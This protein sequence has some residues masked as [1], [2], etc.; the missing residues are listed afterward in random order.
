M[1]AKATVCCHDN[2][3]HSSEARRRVD[4]DNGAPSL[5]TLSGE[6][7][8]GAGICLGYGEGDVPPTALGYLSLSY[9][10]CYSIHRTI[11]LSFGIME[12]NGSGNRLAWV[13]RRRFMPVVQP[14]KCRSRIRVGT[15][16][17]GGAGHKMKLM[18]AKDLNLYNNTNNHTELVS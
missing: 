5:S 13:Y 10:I 3:E 18:L 12:W 11:T 8:L 7:D 14:R 4:V 9:S 15:K 16:A 1:W 17:N 2:G 6:G